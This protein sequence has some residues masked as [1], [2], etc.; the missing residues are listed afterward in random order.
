MTRRF[1]PL[2]LLSVLILAGCKKEPPI[3][4]PEKGAPIEIMVVFAPGQL[5]DQGYADSV[6]EG[7]NSLDHFD[8]I[9]QTDSLDIR[10]MA[11]YNAKDAAESVLEWAGNPSRP[12][13]SG[14]YDRRLLVLTEP[15]M[16]GF[17][18]SV[19][20]K[21]RPTDEVLLLKLEEYDIEQISKQ[22]SLGNRV[23][24]LNISA[25][26][27]VKKYCDFIKV[28]ESVDYNPYINHFSIPMLRLFPNTEYPYRD[29]IEE[30]IREELGDETDLMVFSLSDSEGEGIYSSDNSQTVVEAA[31]EW[32]SMIDLTATQSNC[33]FAIVDLGAGNA[34]W[35]YFL[36][37][38]SAYSNVLTFMIDAKD[39]FAAGRFYVNRHFGMAFMYWVYDWLDKP[40]GAMDVQTTHSDSFWYEDNIIL[41]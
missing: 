30:T 11:P 1:L 40:V 31:Y 3:P 37:G 16:A 5:G 32:A 25:R 9:T 2:V 7:V 22:F 33:P 23:H 38:Q 10:F 12:F 28:V 36:L 29:G 21:L 13:S 35:N 41:N 6:M 14:E 17:L 27:S 20:E 26:A 18:Q 15:F 19:A 24:G 4:E 8:D 39:S 34:G